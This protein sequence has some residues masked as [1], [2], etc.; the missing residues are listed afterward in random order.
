MDSLKFKNLFKYNKL[1]KELHLILYLK[2]CI[3]IN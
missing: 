1:V 2:G 3:F